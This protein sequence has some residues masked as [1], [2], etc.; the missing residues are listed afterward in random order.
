MHRATFVRSILPA[1]LLSPLAACQS[2]TE[3]PGA[4]EG[5]PVPG[6]TV[7][8]PTA[9]A[10]TGALEI[11]VVGLP[12]GAQAQIVVTAPNGAYPRPVSGNATFEML[13]PASY[14]IIARPIQFG[15]QHWAPT[16]E[17]DVV[18]VTAGSRVVAQVTYARRRFGAVRVAAA[19]IPA[20]SVASW[21]LHDPMGATIRAGT[22]ADGGAAIVSE[23]PGGTYTV[24][25]RETRVPSGLV[26]VH[27]Y[28]ATQE[29]RTVV[30]PD[31]GEAVDASARYELATGT[32]RFSALGIPA[33]AGTQR[34][35]WSVR[36]VQDDWMTPLH[37]F[38]GAADRPGY[39]TLSAGDYLVAW[40]RMLVSV[41]GRPFTWAPVDTPRVVAVPRSL[42]PVDVAVRY[43]L[44]TG[45]MR[46]VATG[47]P[48]GA[49]VHW[50]ILLEGETKAPRDPDA[51]GV[52][53]A[54]GTLGDGQEAIVTN[55]IP[56]RYTVQWFDL[57]TT[58]GSY[59]AAVATQVITVGASL[60]PV[61]V[62]GHYAR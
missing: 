22:L 53:G 1:L 52:T 36:S 12:A 16:R 28:R 24:L 51:W 62:E 10:T 35:H 50:E 39:S 29:T 13:A 34:A 49:G 9:P 11:I 2:P 57:G 58:Q 43:V 59:R 6:D 26:G 33:Q 45:A 41:D 19:G 55:L 48:Q 54:A 7:G 56:G 37:G 3:S 18:A 32:L 38:A 4:R 40:A 25:W 20:G 23:L 21:E 31:S 15:S 44:A 61:P 60:D 27:A 47:L 30:V 14:S 8:A 5:A 46:L 17:H 42:D